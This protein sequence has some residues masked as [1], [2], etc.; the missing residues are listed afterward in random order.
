MSTLQG[1]D[2][3]PKATL[4]RWET[5]RNN[6]WED[7]LHLRDECGTKHNRHSHAIPR[8][9]ILCQIVMVLVQT[10]DIS[11]SHSNHRC[12]RYK[13]SIMLRTSLMRWE[14]KRSNYWEDELYFR[15]ECGTKH[16]RHSPAIPRDWTLSQVV[17]VL[18]H[19]CG[20]SR[21]HLN[22]RCQSYEISTMLKKSRISRS[23]MEGFRPWKEILSISWF[24][25]LKSLVWWENQRNNYKL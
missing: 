9:W 16:N 5:K 24:E 20:I 19:T 6:Y 23:S 21:S 10:Y 3:A 7:E 18:V 2:H 25:L 4:V 11:R 12:Q 22:H 15:D 8:D 13:V 17:L 14:I 1:I